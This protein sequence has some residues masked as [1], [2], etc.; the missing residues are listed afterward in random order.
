LYA[1]EQKLQWAKQIE[2]ELK[3]TRNEVLKQAGIVRQA[4]NAQKPV[5]FVPTRTM[6]DP[7]LSEMNE[8]TFAKTTTPLRTRLTQKMDPD[9]TR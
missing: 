4:K 3:Y 7:L 1:L 5:R 8:A 6:L 2:H 9:Y